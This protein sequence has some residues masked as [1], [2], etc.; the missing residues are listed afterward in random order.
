[1]LN[2]GS[3]TIVQLPYYLPDWNT[4]SKSESEPGNPPATRPVR[5]AKGPHPP[6]DAALVA[7]V[8]RRAPCRV[9]A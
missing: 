6:G 5:T 8:R 2:D 9:L 3:T 4:V 7:R 1:A